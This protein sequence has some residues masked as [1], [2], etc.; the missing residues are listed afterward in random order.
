M[1]FQKGLKVSQELPPY[2]LQSFRTRSYV[3]TTNNPR[4]KLIPR[5][6]ASSNYSTE[7]L[8]SEIMASFKSKRKPKPNQS[9]QFTVMTNHT[10]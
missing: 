6:R 2:E 10:S 8:L 5:A 7:N 1:K 9:A 4:G 3:S